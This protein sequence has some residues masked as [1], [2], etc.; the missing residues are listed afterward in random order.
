MLDSCA[1]MLISRYGPKAIGIQRAAVKIC[2]AF[3]MCHCKYADIKG[4]D[5]EAFREKMPKCVVDLSV[6][7]FKLNPQ[8]NMTA[9]EGILRQGAACMLANDVY[10][11]DLTVAL[12]TIKW[13]RSTVF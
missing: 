3:R 6:L 10:T 13:L 11:D 1:M 7:S 2:M 5:K 12:V 4:S 8:Y 9:A